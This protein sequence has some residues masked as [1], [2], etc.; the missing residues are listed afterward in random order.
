MDDKSL[1]KL[2]LS[3]HP[4]SLHPADKQRFVDY[5]FECWKS[6]IDVDYDAL[7]NLPSHVEMH[8]VDVVP[9]LFLAFGKLKEM[10]E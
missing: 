10:H 6:N 1:L 5:V 8:L 4:E 2:F 7:K 9:W 3:Q